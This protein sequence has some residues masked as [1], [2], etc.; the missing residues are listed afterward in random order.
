MMTQTLNTIVPNTIVS[1]PSRQQLGQVWTHPLMAE[2]AIPEPASPTGQ[3]PDAVWSTAMPASSFAETNQVP[4]PPSATGQYPDELWTTGNTTMAQGLE[5][6]S[7]TADVP[8]PP[9]AI[10]Q[11]PDEVWASPRPEAPVESTSPE[12]VSHIQ[13]AP[14]TPETPPSELFLSFKE[15]DYADDL[16]L[17]G[18][19]AQMSIESDGQ[20]DLSFQE[21]YRIIR[22]VAEADSG[23]DLYSALSADREYETP[24]QP[25]HQTR[26]FGLG[27]GLVLFPQES[28]LLGK[29]LRI[30]QRRDTVAFTSLFAPHSEALLTT[31]NAATAQERL[32]PVGGELLWREPWLT[33]FHQAGG[34]PAFQT[35]QNEAAIE[36]QFRPMLGIAY[37]LGFRSDRAL[38][39]V[40]DRIVTRGLGGGLRWVIQSVTPLQTEEQRRQALR[41]LG[42]DTIATFQAASPGLPQT[43]QFDLLTHAAMVGA[44]RR[45]GVMTISPNDAVARLLAA[46]QGTAKQRLLR[47]QTLSQF[48]DVIYRLSAMT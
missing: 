18:N 2:E 30:M 22:R 31:A 27:F 14:T 9:S 4:E 46:A 26:H 39:M 13:S 19:L 35:A 28:G 40:Y 21:I 32:Q 6:A 23:A 17:S 33:R 25:A 10:G 37:E 8:E 16:D 36:H 24:G 7:D 38:A 44:L 5:S 47:L 48:E 34:L 43:G 12:P 42:Y 3:Y 20:V 11:Y 29:L 41:T 45:Q 15:V 1:N